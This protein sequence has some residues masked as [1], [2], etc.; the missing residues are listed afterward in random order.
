MLLM[1]VQ[2]AS[3]LPFDVEGHNAEEIL[4][5]TTKGQLFGAFPRHRQLSGEHDVVG[6]Q[7]HL[8]RLLRMEIFDFATLALWLRPRHEPFVRVVV[9]F[10][11]DAL[12]CQGRNRRVRLRTDDGAEEE[13]KHLK[14][15]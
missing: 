12:D 11:V 7:P 2:G 4:L 8:K 9:A 14:R 5:P 3:Y 6:R 13:A 10:V 15:D 1:L